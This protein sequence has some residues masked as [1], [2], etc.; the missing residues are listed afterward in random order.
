MD[1]TKSKESKQVMLE[2]LETLCSFAPR[3]AG[4]KNEARTAEYIANY[5]DDMAT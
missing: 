2:N 4:S 5:F 3:V 1:S